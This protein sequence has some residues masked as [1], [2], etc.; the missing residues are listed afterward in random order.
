MAK[1][2]N[3]QL[4]SLE[5]LLSEREAFL[6]QDIRREVEMSDEY[7]QLAGEAPD[8]GDSAT[9]DL[10]VDLNNAAVGR[11]VNELR[12][13]AAARE[14]IKEGTYGHCLGCGLDIPYERLRAQPTAER[15]TPC[16]EVYEK[17]HADAGRG[18]TL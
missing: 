11:D 6:Q 4:A 12:H 9:A 13:I 1:L 5:A 8:A 3:E 15:C 10:V 7:K 18:A 2:T 16:Q 14:R 17:T